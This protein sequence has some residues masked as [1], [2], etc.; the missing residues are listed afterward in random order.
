V[1]P[2]GLSITYTLPVSASGYD[3]T[4]ITVYGGWA[5]AGR[6]EQK[7]NVYYSTVAAPT[8]WA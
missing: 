6:N 5:D 2:A 7:Y 1:N 4:N 3:L 8:S